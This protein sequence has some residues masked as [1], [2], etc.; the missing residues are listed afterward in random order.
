M[1][2]KELNKAR[3]PYQ[4]SNHVGWFSAF[5]F[6]FLAFATSAN[7]DVMFISAGIGLILLLAKIAI[8]PKSEDFVAKIV[9]EWLQ[10]IVVIATFGAFTLRND[11]FKLSLFAVIAWVFFWIYALFEVHVYMRNNGRR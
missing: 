2:H 5:G 9:Q 8:A 6:G 7:G 1:A 3:V 10:Q 4:G 11:P